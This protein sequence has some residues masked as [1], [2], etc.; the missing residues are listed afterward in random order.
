VLLSSEFAVSLA[1]K[2]GTKLHI[3]HISTAKETDL[4]TNDLPLSQKRITAEVCIH[5]MWFDE[6]DYASKGI[7]NKMESC[8]KIEK[9]KEAVF[10]A[11]LD[12]RIDVVATDHAPHLMDEKKNPIFIRHQAGLCTT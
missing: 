12:D 5:H 3:L 8:G 7:F 11:L 6:N 2:F 4:F 10:Q 9:D 1:K